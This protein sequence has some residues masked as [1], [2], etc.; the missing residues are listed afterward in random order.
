MT[1]NSDY[2]PPDLKTLTEG[3]DLINTKI[4]RLFSM[5]NG[6]ITIKTKQVIAFLIK[7]RQIYKMK[8]F[9]I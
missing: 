7:K 2:T 9:K 1:I 5:L 4:V 6:I 3:S 8:H